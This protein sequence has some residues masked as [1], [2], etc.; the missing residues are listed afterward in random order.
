LRLFQGSP[1]AAPINLPVDRDQSEFE[2]PPPLPLTEP[3]TSLSVSEFNA[4][5]DCPYRFYLQKVMRLQQVDDR[6]EE[7]DAS[8]FGTLAHDVLEDFANSE[9]RDASEAAEIRSYLIE[10][11]RERVRTHFGRQPRPTVQV[12]V[13]QLQL[14][15][16]AFAD[17]QARWRD[18]GWQITYAEHALPDGGVSFLVDQQPLQLRGRIDRIDYHPERQ[19]YAILDY[20]TGEAG[21]SPEKKHLLRRKKGEP[22]TP[23]HWKN[24]QLPLYRHLVAEMGLAGDLELGYILLPSDPSRTR[25]ELAKW[26]Q[27]EL[28]LAD[29]AARHV[30]RSIRQEIFWPPTDPAPYPNDVFAAICQEGIFGRRVRQEVVEA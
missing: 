18:A 12:Q 6:A 26:T 5:L 19:A 7:L 22:L 10:R 17:Q 13:A 4:Y 27:E 8:K 16:A 9:I 11:L 20:K 14:R 3:I 21:D 15:L 24:L 1:D 2:V 23:A 30:V 25:F 28:G 29:E